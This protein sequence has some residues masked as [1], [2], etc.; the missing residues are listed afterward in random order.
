MGPTQRRVH[1]LK[2]RN[3]FVCIT[4][5]ISTILEQWK[6][7][8]TKGN[9]NL[10]KEDDFSVWDTAMN[11]SML[12]SSPHINTCYIKLNNIWTK[13]KIVSSSV[14]GVSYLY[15]QV[16]WQ[17][18]SVLELYCCWFG[19]ALLHSRAVHEERLGYNGKL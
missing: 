2:M 18:L 7:K 17:L 9:W 14:R 11:S 10:L 19:D 6:I 5:H 13:W 3:L 12:Y 4:V 16:F 8:G 15:S 1:L